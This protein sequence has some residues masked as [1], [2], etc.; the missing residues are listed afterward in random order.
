MFNKM[1]LGGQAIVTGRGS[2]GYIGTIPAKKAF[3]V[4]GGR[5]MYAN[6][7]IAK[8]EAMLRDKGC[9]TLVHGGIGANPDTTAVEAG[10]DAM[11][12]FGPD[13]LVAVG[14]GSPLDAAK[15]MALF[16]EYPELNFG[17]VLSR[18]LPERRQKLTFVAAPSTSGTGSEV[19]KAAVITFREQNLKIGLKTT[20]MIPD[21]AILDPDLTLTMPPN[22]VAETGMDALTHAVECYINT[23]MDAFLE[24]L[25]RGAVEGIFANLPAS[26]REGAPESRENMHIYQCMAGLAFSHV[27]LGMAHGIAHAVGGRFGLGHGLI[28]AIVLPQVLQYNSR[29]AEVR[30]RLQRLAKS[31]GEAD[32]IDAVE[33]LNRQLHIPASFREAGLSQ[34]D[35]EAAFD[36]LVEN[37]MKGST[38][39]NPAPVS[40][41]EMASLLRQLFFG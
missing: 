7:T 18:E 11:R 12:A 30:N 21:V 4:T 26:Y 8:I 36:E 23:R 19:T 34:Q 6:G 41:A 35:V 33:R 16:Y 15:A 29:D 1:V 32:F 5:S 27:G 3:I 9:E 31:I 22:I 28:N 25:A 37:A 20:A 24:P 13:L 10:V 17:N 40:T 38:R 2:I 14:G 39:V